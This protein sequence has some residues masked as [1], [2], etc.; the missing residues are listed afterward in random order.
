MQLKR[1]FS[2]PNEHQKWKLNKLNFNQ[3]LFNTQSFKW[4]GE[5]HVHLGYAE[6]VFNH[7]GV[8]VHA[9]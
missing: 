7:Q 3:S 4:Q 1:P 9:L 5:I 2:P 8:T 6:I